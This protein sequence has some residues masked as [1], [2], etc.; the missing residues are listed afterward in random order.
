[1]IFLN[2]LGTVNIYTERCLLRR[3]EPTDAYYVF[4]SYSSL[5][6][7]AKFLN[8]ESHKTIFE[9][10]L[11]I[12]EF[13]KNYNNLNYYNW[14]IVENKTNTIIGTISIH[15]IDLYNDKGEIGIIISPYYQKKGYAKEVVGAVINFAFYKLNIHRLE[16]KVMLDNKASNNL[17][18]NLKFIFEGVLFS[19]IKKNNQFFDVNLYSLINL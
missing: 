2:S 8:N 12:Y 6:N 19:S 17:F 16:A 18:R 9:T 5:E 1:M 10:E 7:V 3:F 14:V 11:M 13:L 4:K 15:E